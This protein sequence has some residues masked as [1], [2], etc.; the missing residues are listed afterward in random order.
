[1][2]EFYAEELTEK[3]TKAGLDSRFARLAHV[4]R[5]GSPTVRDRFSATRL[6]DRAV[7]LILE[8]RKN[9]IVGFQYNKLVDIDMEYALNLDRRY[10]GKL[11]DEQFAQL[12]EAD[13][14]NIS[15]HIAKKQADINNLFEMSKRMSI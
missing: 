13:R 7:E 9:L 4:Q 11:T 6:G 1:M 12:S 8:G 5:G 15:E 3:M 14:K 2:G 10:K